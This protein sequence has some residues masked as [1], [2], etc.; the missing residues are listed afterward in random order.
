MVLW[1]GE[2][3]RE[4]GCRGNCFFTTWAPGEGVEEEMVAG[5]VDNDV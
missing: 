3:A 4:K 2:R 5:G 1:E